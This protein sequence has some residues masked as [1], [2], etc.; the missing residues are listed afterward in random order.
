MRA[1]KPLPRT[2]PQE[3]KT[4]GE[5]I[6]K[7][8]I[9][10]GVCRTAC[11]GRIGV[12]PCTITNWTTGRVSPG[13][14]HLPGIIEFLGYNPFNSGA[15]SIGDRIILLRKRLG[16]SRKALAQRLGVDPET[17]ARWEK[18]ISVPAQK[19]LEFLESLISPPTR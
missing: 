12:C 10:L 2:Y 6:Q 14:E 5:H 8:M 1:K 11:A 19:H 9:D 15:E 17:A 4:I 3:P 18:D 16:L 7:R 13:V